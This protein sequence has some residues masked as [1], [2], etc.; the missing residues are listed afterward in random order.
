MIIQAHLDEL[1][2]AGL[3]RLASAMRDVEYLFRHG[4]IQE[5]V[6]STLLRQQRRAWHLAAGEA[7][8]HLTAINS[9]GAEAL[10]PVLAQ[11]FSIAGDTGRALIYFTRAADAAFERYALAEAGDYYAQALGLATGEQVP[12]EPEPVK[13]LATRLGLTLELRSQF[14]AALRHYEALEGHARQQ[15]D[16]ALEL[17]MLLEQA[18]I[19]ATANRTQDPARSQA[20]LERA[21]PL[22]E[23]VGDH[24]TEAR[25]LWT[26]ML[27]NLM[28]GGDPQERL[29]YGERAL[30]LARAHDLREQLA[31]IYQDMFYAYGGLLRWND[32]RHALEQ[33]CRLWTE[34]NHPV[35]LCESTGRLAIV[36]ML[37][38]DLGQALA[39]ADKAHQI[40]T[41]IRSPDMQALSHAFVGLMH[42]EHGDYGRA[43]TLAEAAVEHGTDSG[44]V[45]VM[46]GSRAE[47]GLAYAE[48]GDLQ[49]GLALARAAHAFAQ[50][51]IR[52][53]NGWSGGVL[54]R[55]QVLAGDL[56]AAAA[57]LAELQP[58]QAYLR[59][60]G[61]MAMIWVQRALAEAELA[62][63]QGQ[64]GH[65]ASVAAEA[66]ATATNSGMRFRVPDLLL[67]RARALRAQGRLAQ[68][69][70][71]LQA[72][73]LEAIALDSRRM[74]WRILAALA[75]IEAGTGQPDAARQ[76]RRQ[77]Q[78]LIGYI[79]EQAPAGLRASFLAQPEVRAVVIDRDE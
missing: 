67:V 26:L 69:R 31:F 53:L 34:L 21:A 79:A 43:I 25:L 5:A 7:L 66:A 42:A 51:H 71:D 4:L 75:E 59:Q 29:D 44:N 72:A 8:E 70:S 1:E 28:R 15:G 36:S 50:T 56:P 9:P 12:Y 60:A 18:K 54:A 77:A 13:H 39:L 62:L 40:A 23:R 65:A 47:L 10:A 58:V 17:A 11:H 33:A 73:R 16:L 38:G 48:L 35:G 57:T 19:Y 52:L 55:L 24:A 6:Y 64:A 46:T 41:R 30:G 22:A 45:T 20:L 76:W 2:H 63:A 61:F 14:E 27:Q 3:I 32:T 49:R 74:Q 68:A 78:T 37:T